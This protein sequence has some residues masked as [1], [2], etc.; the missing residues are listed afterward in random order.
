MSRK[1]KVRNGMPF[2]DKRV[3]ESLTC[4]SAIKVSLYKCTVLS[5]FRLYG[6]ETWTLAN[7]C[8][9]RSKDS[10]SASL[11][12]HFAATRRIVSTDRF[13]LYPPSEGRR[14]VGGQKLLF[15]QYISRVIEGGSVKPTEHAAETETTGVIWLPPAGTTG[16]THRRNLI[17]LF[18]ERLSEKNVHATIPKGKMGYEQYTTFSDKLCRNSCI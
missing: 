5:V 9:L 2:G 11:A 3:F 8:H 6:S 4:Q 7:P 14:S 10:S 12:I 16:L 15:L 13:A 1:D 17:Q 18:R